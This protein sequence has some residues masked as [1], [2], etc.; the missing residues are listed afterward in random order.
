ESTD[1]E[2]SDDVIQDANVEG[3]MINEEETPE[4]VEANMLYRDV[5]V[6]LD[7]RDT[8]MTDAPLPNVQA[9]QE[10]EDTHVI[11]TAPINPEGQQQSSSV[12]SGFIFKMLNPRPDTGFD[13]IFNLNTEA[14]SLVDVLVTTIAEPPLV[15]AT[16][17]PLP[18]TPLITHMQQTLV[19]TLT[20]VLS[21]PLQDLPN[22]GSLFRL[23]DEA[24]AK[25]KYFLNKLD[26]NIKKIIKDQVKE[27]VKAQVSKIL[28]RIEKTVNKQLEAEVMTSSSNESKTSH[29]V[30]AN[31]SELELKK[32]LIDKMERNK[33][34]HK[35][36]EQK[37][38]YNALKLTK[39]TNLYLKHMVKLFHLK[40]VEMKRIK[41]KNPL[42]DQTRGR[43]EEELAKNLSQPV[44][45]KKGPPR[46]LASLL[47][48][49]N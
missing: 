28:P 16:T 11:L 29:A 27:E 4:E 48:G 33:S 18:P 42:L 2:D 13:S 36:N 12:P 19:P 49:P 40:D 20:I 34:I 23:R 10:I 14:T 5:N 39:V 21:S 15:F 17:L 31:L 30:A 3:D 35:S 25:N 38:L 22:F 8:V 6:N 46:Q 43:R 37:N 32:I 45:Q 9:A 1:D 44:L 26:D 7:G 41:M 24:Q 47:M